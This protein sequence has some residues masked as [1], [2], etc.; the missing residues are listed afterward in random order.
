MGLQVIRKK[1]QSSQFLSQEKTF[2]KYLKMIFAE[3][4]SM[5]L[6]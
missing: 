5:N 6:R 2:A 3:K 1:I 4:V